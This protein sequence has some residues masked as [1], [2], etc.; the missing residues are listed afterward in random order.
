MKIIITGALGHI[1]SFIIRDFANKYPESEIF[2]IDNMMTQRYSS[3]FNLPKNIKFKFIEADILNFDFNK[4]LSDNDILIHLAAITDAAGSFER[5]EELENNNFNATKKV[6]IACSQ[7]GA[8]LITL[9]STSVYGTQ[10]LVV[11]E[12]CTEEDLKPQSPYAKTKLKEEEFVLNLCQNHGLKAIIC[13]FGTIFG[14]SIGMRFHTA[15]NKFCWQAVM[16]TPITVWSTAFEQKRPYLDLNDASNAF[17]HIIQN[18]I[19]NGAIYNVLTLNAT[20]KEIVEIIQ[21][22]YPRLKINFVDN[23]IMNQLSYEVSNSKFKDTG[24]VFEGNLKNRIFE[25]I[26][27]LKTS[28]YTPKI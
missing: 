15:V 13:R 23:Q 18:N 5:A 20:V 25:T 28:N 14:P 1:G 4:I 3:L 11:S 21:I 24:F 17:S 22:K 8:R 26:D 16:G 7:I 27:L 19:F 2:L 6:A 10:K 9:S 12:N